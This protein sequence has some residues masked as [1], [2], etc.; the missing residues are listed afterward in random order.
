[1]STD[2][3]IDNFNNIAIEF[4]NQLKIVC[5]HSVIANNVDAIEMLIN[6][7]AT[8]SKIIDQFTFYVLKYKDK[9]DEHNED[10]FLHETFETES[11]GNS[12]IIMLISEIK[13]AWKNLC[14]DDKNK[15]FDYLR[16][17]CFYSQ[18]YLL[19]TT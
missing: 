7:Q 16:V 12:S 5:P 13:E 1:M 9:I 8:K 6:N 11:S 10:F 3:I 17:M 18:E 4:I 14:N 2:E 19:I 15:I